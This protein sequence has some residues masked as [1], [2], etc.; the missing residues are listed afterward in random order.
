MNAA[1][2]LQLARQEL[3]LAPVTQ[4]FSCHTPFRLGCAAENA[5]FSDNS[6]QL[7]AALCL[8]SVMNHSYLPCTVESAFCHLFSQ[9]P[10]CIPESHVLL[11]YR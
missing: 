7:R 8:Q 3:K 10:G 9:F 6:F 11:L 5:V 1:R 2:G 4:E